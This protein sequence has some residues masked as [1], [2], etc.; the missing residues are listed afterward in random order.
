MIVSLNSVCNGQSVF[1]VKQEPVVVCQ[2]Y[3]DNFMLHTVKYRLDL[4]LIFLL[5]Y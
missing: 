5:W 1:T 2:Y 3:S 4:Q